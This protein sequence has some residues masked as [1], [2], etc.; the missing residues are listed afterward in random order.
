MSGR[1]V[2]VGRPNVGKSTLF[3]RLLGRREAIVQER[4][5]VTRDPKEE[6]AEWTG[7]EFLLVDTGGWL[8]TGDDLEMKVSTASQ[9]MLDDADVI[10]F[11]VDAEVGLATDD[12]ALVKFLRPFTDRVILVTNKVDHQAR[13]S[14][15]WQF[16][17]LGFGEPIGVAAQGGR[18]IGE[19]L[20]EIVRRLPLDPGEELGAPSI[21]ATDDDVD[22]SVAIVGRPNVGKSTLFNRLVGEEKSI[23]HDMPGTTRDVI[24]TTLETE[25]GKLRFLDTAGMRRSSRV[26]DDTE[27]YSINRA[28]RAIDRANIAIYVLDASEGITMQDARLL[29]RVDGAGCPIV[30]LLN[31]WDKL[32]TEQRAELEKSVGDRLHFLSYSPVLKIS[33]KTGLGVHKLYG[34]LDGA[35][36]GYTTRVPTGEL[37][38]VLQRAQDAHPA[39]GSRILYGTQGASDPP[40]FTIFATRELPRTYLRYIERKIREHFKLDNTPVKIR[41]RKRAS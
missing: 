5:G 35:I 39:P 1:V 21:E 10:L 17:S 37:N 34:A 36:E 16:L 30:L 6:D 18:N 32:N 8:A 14:D 29:E 38:A 7:R 4:P 40:T 9:R 41:V 27:F 19:L 15:V 12:E 3:N 33:A 31:K 20:D 2:I 28:L 23:V 24:D 13:E 22:Y 26:D 25:I 11:V